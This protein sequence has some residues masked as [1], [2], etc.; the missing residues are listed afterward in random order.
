MIQGSA[1]V[2]LPAAEGDPPHYP[3]MTEA[4]QMESQIGLPNMR[5]AYFRGNTAVLGGGGL[6]R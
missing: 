6:P 1:A 4:A 5:A 3:E 2:D